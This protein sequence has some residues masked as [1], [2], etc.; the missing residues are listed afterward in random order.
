MD[1]FDEHFVFFVAEPSAGA[2]AKLLP[3]REILLKSKVD[4]VDVR[5]LVHHGEQLV[6]Y[7]GRN[8]DHCKHNQQVDDIDHAKQLAFFI[9]NFHGI[10]PVWK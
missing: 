1:R 6:A 10:P 3:I 2:A 7:A 9:D 5:Y 4:E 8:R